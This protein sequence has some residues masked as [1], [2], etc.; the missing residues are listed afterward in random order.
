M[1]LLKVCPPGTIKNNAT[2]RCVS[3]Q[4]RTGKQLLKNVTFE[5]SKPKSPKKIFPTKRK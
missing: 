2:G 3:K 5:K 1:G 4:G